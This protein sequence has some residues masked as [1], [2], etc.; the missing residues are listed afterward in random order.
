[1]I[2]Q[3]TIKMQE[4]PARHL[5]TRIMESCEPLSTNMVSTVE[6]INKYVICFVRVVP[7]DKVSSIAEAAFIPRGEG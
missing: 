7:N 3:D 5:L 6:V 4:V 2:R 1:M